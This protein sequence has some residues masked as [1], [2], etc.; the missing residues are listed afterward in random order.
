[1]KKTNFRPH[2]FLT[3]FV[4]GISGLSMVACTPTRTRESAS[5]YSKDALVT[6]RVKAALV[7]EPNLKSMPISVDTFRGTVQL[8]GFVDNA[9]QIA[10]AVSVTRGVEGVEA[11]KNDLHV[12]TR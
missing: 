12:K 9:T 7:K 1:M 8:S 5:E 11:V 2:S 6:A 4:I 10:R 3:A